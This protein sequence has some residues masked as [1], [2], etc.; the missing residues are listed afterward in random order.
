MQVEREALTYKVLK[1]VSRTLLTLTNQDEEAGGSGNLNTRLDTSTTLGSYPPG[2]T[3][4]EKMK[5][6][7][8]P[9]PSKWQDESMSKC[10]PPPSSGRWVGRSLQQCQLSDPTWSTNNAS[11]LVPVEC[12]NKSRQIRNDNQLNHFSEKSC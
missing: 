2:A 11:G 7:E 4:N 10:T 1:N 3:K 6:D 5:N 12:C 8:V 9:Q